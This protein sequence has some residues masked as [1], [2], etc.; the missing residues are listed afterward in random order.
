[1]S[2][3][4]I[5]RLVR[6]TFHPEKVGD[7]LKLF[8]E[9]NGA[10]RCFEGCEKLELWQDANRPNVFTTYSIWQDNRSLEEYRQSDLFKENWHQAR[11]LF[12]RPAEANSFKQVDLS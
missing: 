6:M 7:F 9:I 10:I 11:A 5:I 2:S 8:G 12:I 3:F 1:M 4:K